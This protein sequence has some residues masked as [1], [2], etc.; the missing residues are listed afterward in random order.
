[1]KEKQAD[2][3]GYANNRVDE[4]E[5]QLALEDQL[6]MKNCEKPPFVFSNKVCVILSQTHTK[7]SSLL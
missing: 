5:R 7:A 2:I 4:Y 6:E 3:S 1:V